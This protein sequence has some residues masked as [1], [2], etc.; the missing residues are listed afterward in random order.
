MSMATRTDETTTYDSEGRVWNVST[1]VLEGDGSYT[2][3]T[4]TEVNYAYDEEGRVIFVQTTTETDDPRED[5][6]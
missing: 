4:K 6:K 1:V 3:A 2:K 5:A